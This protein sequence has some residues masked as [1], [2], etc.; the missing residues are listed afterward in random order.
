M[1]GWLRIDCGQHTRPWVPTAGRWVRYPTADYRCGL[2]G[3]TDSA[4]GDAVPSFVATIRRI[5][6]ID[7]P[8][9][10]KSAR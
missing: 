10:E 7:C 5:H 8:A 1:V 3:F 2:C 9:Q 6:Q 4:S